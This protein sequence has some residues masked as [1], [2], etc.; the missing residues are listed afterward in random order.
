MLRFPSPLHPALPPHQ[1][2]II[3]SAADENFFPLVKGLYLSLIDCQL[4]PGKIELGFIDIGNG[5]EVLRWMDEHKVKVRDTRNVALSSAI[6]NRPEFAYTQAQYV[7]PFIPEIFPG[8]D[9]YVWLDSDTWVQDG[10]TIRSL[11]NTVTRFP[12]RLCISPTVDVGY[13]K[14]YQDYGGYLAGYDRVYRVCFDEHVAAAMRGRAVFSSGVFAFSA[15]NPLWHA[16][17]E[18]LA[19]V[20]SKDYSADPDALHIAEQLALNVV[21]YRSGQFVAIDASHNFHCHA[22]A[23]VIRDPGSR[24]VVLETQ[25][26][27]RLGIIHLSD[28]PNEKERYLAD[29]LLW[30][31]GAYLT[32]SELQNLRDYRRL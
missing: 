13:E 18:Q 19:V 5:P 21:A 3:V 24:R 25:P 4:P 27:R 9:Y 29:K 26:E 11:L 32:A 7:R 2:A 23:R 22:G 28:F 1:R 31:E 6:P 20:Y 15:T 10:E 16:W 17:R 14:F 30:N 8:Y 12:D